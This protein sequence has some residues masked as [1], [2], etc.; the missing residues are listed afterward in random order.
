MALKSENSPR[1]I[2]VFFGFTWLKKIAF[3]T[4][5]INAVDYRRRN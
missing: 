2:D 5:R 1:D 4:V 3:I